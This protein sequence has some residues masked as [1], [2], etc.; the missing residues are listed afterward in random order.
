[1]ERR[2]FKRWAKRFRVRFWGRGSEEEPRLGHTV[3]ISKRGMY[4]GTGKPLRSGTRVRVEILD[5]DEGFVVE[6]VVTHSHEV[7]PELLKIKPSGMGVRL[8]GVRELVEGLVGERTEPPAESVA[9]AARVP[10]E[11][12]SVGAEPEPQSQSEA[13]YRV[14]FRDRRHF[15]EVFQREVIRGGMVVPTRDPA[16]LDQVISLEIVPPTRRVE[17]F[18]VRARVV[19]TVQPSATSSGGGSKPYS[20][21]GVEFED[22]E[23]AFERFE[24]VAR[25]LGG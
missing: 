6:G 14:R 3:N 25:R 8:L 2:S 16:R 9:P 17:A 4:I 7:A 21:M 19:H 12:P 18:E 13:S 1:M 23:L 24:A 10:A 11:P 20:G 15:R 5:P 22:A